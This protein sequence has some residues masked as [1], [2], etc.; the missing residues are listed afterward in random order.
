MQVQGQCMRAIS[1][2]PGGFTASGG[3]QPQPAFD[4]SAPPTLTQPRTRCLF[5]L[6]RPSTPTRLRPFGS[7]D[8]NHALYLLAFPPPAA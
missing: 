7:A 6:R 4:L 3:L 2:L 8:L 1:R 5:R